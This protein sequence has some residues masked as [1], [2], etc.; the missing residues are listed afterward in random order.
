MVESFAIG[1]AAQKG[2][3]QFLQVV[4]I[5]GRRALQSNAITLV[6]RGGPGRVCQ[7]SPPP[8]Q[9]NLPFFKGLST[10]DGMFLACYQL[11]VPS[12]EL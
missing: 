1:G 10:Q 3:L 5:G 2:R 7:V 11:S 12:S 8:V 6:V 4:T 9:I